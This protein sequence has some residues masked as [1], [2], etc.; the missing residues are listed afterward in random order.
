MIQQARVSP[1]IPYFQTPF[2]KR[3]FLKP[4][5]NAF[6]PTIFFGCYTNDDLFAIGWHQSLA[7]VA[8]AGSDAM[9]LQKIMTNPSGRA[10]LT[11]PNVKHL[12]IGKHIERDLEAAG[13]PLVS[14]PL[15]CIDESLFIP[16]APTGNGIYVYLPK[17]DREKYGGSFIDELKARLPN[18][19]WFINDGLR[20]KPEDMPKIYRRCIT[21]VRA[22]KHDGLSNTVVEMGLMGRKVLWNG[23]TPNAIPFEAVEDAAKAIEELIDNPPDYQSV[24]AATRKYLSSAG[25]SWKRVEYYTTGFKT[26]T[27]E[28]A[29]QP[30]D[31]QRYFNFRYGQGERGAGGPEPASEEAWK[32]R[33]FVLEKLNANHVESV[34][35]I[36]CGSMVRWGAPCRD[37]YTGIDVSGVAIEQA[38]QRFPEHTFIRR[39]V[40]ADDIPQ[41]DAIVC[42][43][44]FQHITPLDAP[45]LLRKMIDA[46]SKCVIIKTSVNIPTLYYQF[47]HQW[48]NMKTVAT[49]TEFSEHPVPGAPHARFFLFEKR[50][51]PSAGEGR[52]RCCAAVAVPGP[53][54]CCKENAAC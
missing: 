53:S 12:A 40:V 6:L 14:V 22:T 47:D 41:A 4:Y 49:D 20:Y 45:G 8:W 16:E 15:C 46:A 17:H 29:E 32:T 51:S 28:V 38:R 44:M 5:T 33:E 25:E 2:H 35:E 3:Y 30:Y 24:A 18:R 11:R 43:D 48:D 7:V 36:G 26:M 50:T 21:G 19:E 27:P 52:G 34:V 1:S 31:Y 23:G 39:D 54:F 13:L 42:I 37:N 10:L 9:N